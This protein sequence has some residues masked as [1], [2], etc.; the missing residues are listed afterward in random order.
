M[1]EA[2]FLSKRHVKYIA[3]SFQ[4]GLVK[5]HEY[6]M[7]HGIALAQHEIQKVTNLN[8]RLDTRTCS[9]LPSRA[10]NST[11]SDCGFAMTVLRNLYTIQSLWYS[12]H[13]HFLYMYFGGINQWF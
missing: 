6:I 10:H 1:A 3:H 9:S 2:P 8:S 13:V 4:L 12:F 5:F 7:C 11:W